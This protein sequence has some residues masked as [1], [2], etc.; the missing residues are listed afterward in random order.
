MFMGKVVG[1][2]WATRK[3]EELAPYIEAAL[4]RKQYL[5]PLTD[6]DIPIVPPSAELAGTGVE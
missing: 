5:K 2:V 1:T 6:A 3:D 4:A